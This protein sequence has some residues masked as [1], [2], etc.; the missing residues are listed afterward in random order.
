MTQMGKTK[1]F[2]LAINGF[3]LFH[4]P[5]QL[6]G[7]TDPFGNEI[8]NEILPCRVT[9]HFLLRVCFFNLYINWILYVVFLF[10]IYV[11]FQ[12]PCEGSLLNCNS[13]RQV[14]SSQTLD[15]LHQSKLSL[16]CFPKHDPEFHSNTIQFSWVQTSS[17]VTT[18]KLFEN[19]SSIIVCYMVNYSSKHVN[20]KFLE[21]FIRWWVIA[22]THNIW[23]F[24]KIF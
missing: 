13:C 17:S 16:V 2:Y 18:G 6:P 12:K 5:L 3:R 9:I 14:N 4:A 7:S 24:A 10:N 8:G 23:F 15:L 22:V 1:L 11:F 20:L 19:F 21:R